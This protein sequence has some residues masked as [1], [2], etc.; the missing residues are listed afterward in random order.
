[1]AGSTTAGSATAGSTT[2]GSTAQGV[3]PRRGFYH[4]GTGKITEPFKQALRECGFKAF[5]G[6]DA[7]VQ[8]GHLQEVML[9]ETAVAWVRALQK[10]TSPKQPWEETREASGERMRGIARR[11]NS[12]YNVEGLCREFPD[13]IQCLIDVEGDNPKK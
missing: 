7:S 1:M 3:L 8:P 11:V 6:N 2:A 12:E 10:T 13:R 9:H 5:W 4:S